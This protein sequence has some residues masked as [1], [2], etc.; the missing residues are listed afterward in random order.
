MN[1]SNM[2]MW[3]SLSSPLCDP[4]WLRTSFQKNE[5]DE[6]AILEKELEEEKQALMEQTQDWDSIERTNMERSNIEQVEEDQDYYDDYWYVD[7][8]TSEE[9]AEPQSPFW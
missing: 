6:L 5:E 2:N 7:D 9:F 3:P 4:I 1:A 8:A